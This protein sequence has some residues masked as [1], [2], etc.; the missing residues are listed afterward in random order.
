MKSIK[1]IDTEN[2]PPL[3]PNIQL[4]NDYISSPITKKSPLKS[5]IAII[6][7][8]SRRGRDLPTV[9]KVSPTSISIEDCVFN[10]DFVE[11]IFQLVRVPVV[12]DSLAGYNTIL[13]TGIR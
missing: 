8:V 10:F 4:D 11:D 12:K 5:I 6:R 7:P 9:R 2:T 1:S 3:D 13:W